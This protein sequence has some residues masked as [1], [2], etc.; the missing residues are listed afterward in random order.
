MEIQINI[1]T[2]ATDTLIALAADL[3]HQIDAQDWTADDEAN[4]LET[5][6]A[7]LYGRRSDTTGMDEHDAGMMRLADMDRIDAA[8][9]LAEANAEVIDTL[10][11]GLVM[12][13]RI[14]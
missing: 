1:T 12:A 2:L 4:T 14:C 13:G 3:S 7:H 10:T 5:I 9:R 8:L 11:S 6:L